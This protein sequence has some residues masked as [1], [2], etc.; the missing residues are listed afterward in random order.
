MGILYNFD[1][2]LR[3]LFKVSTVNILVLLC[4]ILILT[5]T[6][7]NTGSLELFTIDNNYLSEFISKYIQNIN[8]TTDFKNTLATQ[9][10][11][12]NILADQVINLINTQK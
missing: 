7:L 12:I 4:L 3:N 1:K 8:N 2:G 11:K 9:E 10:Q 5:I 6:Y